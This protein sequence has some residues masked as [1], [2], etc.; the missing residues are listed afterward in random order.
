VPYALDA[1][2]AVFDG[3]GNLRFKFGRRGAELRYRDRDHRNIGRSAS[4]VTASLVKLIQ[5]SSSRMI[6][7]TMGESG[8][9]IDHAE[10]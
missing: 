5:P 6:E 10:I 9:R 4:R 2:H 3:L 1:G 8:F 7:K